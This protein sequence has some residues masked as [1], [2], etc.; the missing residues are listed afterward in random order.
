VRLVQLLA[1]VANAQPD[2]NKQNHPLRGT[3]QSQA[4]NAANVGM[5]AE[6]V[7]PADHIKALAPGLALSIETLSVCTP[8]KGRCSKTQR[9][10][11]GQPSG[12][13]VPPTV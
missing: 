3:A 4:H 9:T 12:L 11:Q 2:A 10:P 1:N 6:E 8:K 13:P 7:T 5:M